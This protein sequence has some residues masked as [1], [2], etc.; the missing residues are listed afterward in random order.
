MQG[1]QELLSISKWKYRFQRLRAYQTE[2]VVQNCSIACIASSTI[3]LC[4]GFNLCVLQKM[5]I[6]SRRSRWTFSP[7]HEPRE[8]RIRSLNRGRLE[9]RQ[10]CLDALAEGSSVAF[11]LEEEK[12]GIDG[13]ISSQTRGAFADGGLD[14]ILES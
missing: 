5:G 3:C 13:R 8:H 2:K 6:L 9:L 4:N 14:P 7:F 12:C 10:A 11:F 1:V